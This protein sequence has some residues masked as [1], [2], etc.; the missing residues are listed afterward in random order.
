MNTKYIF[1][2]FLTFKAVYAFAQNDSTVTEKIIFD[3]ITVEKDPLIIKR[4][5]YVTEKRGH[6]GKKYIEA[7][8]GINN[9][10]AFSTLT[11]NSKHQ[12]KNTFSFSLNGGFFTNYLRISAGIG[13]LPIYKRTSRNTIEAFNDTSYYV[14]TDTLDSY[15]TVKNGD[16][17][18]YHITEESTKQKIESK[19]KINEESFERK[20]TLLQIPISLGFPIYIKK[21]LLIPQIGVIGSLVASDKIFK[22]DSNFGNIQSKKKLFLT[23]YFSLSASYQIFNNLSL[24]ASLSYTKNTRNKYSDHT[25]FDQS[26]RIGTGIN[27]FF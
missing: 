20:V 25:I 11:S 24:N 16:T 10:N 7:E 15:F 5:I 27:Y 8:V 2:F 13:M 18:Y 9:F 26:F 21:F 17:T 12:Y 14:S 22:N 23:P 6:S 1:V 4:T 3:T 19:E